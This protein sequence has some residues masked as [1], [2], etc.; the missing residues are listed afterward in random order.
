MAYYYAFLK[1][2]FANVKI[3]R[4]KAD[5]LEKFF[6]SKDVNVAGFRNVKIVTDSDGDLVDIELDE[7]RKNFDDAY[8]FAIKLQECIIS[9]FVDLY[10]EGEDG[11]DKWIRV[12]SRDLRESLKFRKEWVFAGRI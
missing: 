11:D 4:E 7:Y 1:F 3:D 9:G 12:L 8:L 10:F 5:E 2:E 6:A